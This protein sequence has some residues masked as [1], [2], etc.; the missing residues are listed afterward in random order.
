[1][2]EHQWG[3]SSVYIT[4]TWARPA[5]LR[6]HRPRAEQRGKALLAAKKTEKSLSMNR[7][8]NPSPQQMRNAKG[9][10]LAADKNIITEPDTDATRARS[11]RMQ[12]DF[13]FFLVCFTSS[14]VQRCL[15]PPK[16]RAPW[17][18]TPARHILKSS[19]VFYGPWLAFM[20]KLND[21]L[22]TATQSVLQM[23]QTLLFLQRFIRR[24]R[25]REK[26]KGECFIEVK[27]SRCKMQP[28][29]DVI[30]LTIWVRLRG[31]L[32][33][34][35]SRGCFVSSCR[36]P[37]FCNPLPHNYR[38]LKLQWSLWDLI[39]EG[40]NSSSPIVSL[41]LSHTHSAPGNWIRCCVSS[42][43]TLRVNRASVQRHR[44]LA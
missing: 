26:K 15:S 8:A 18:S 6:S 9:P 39:T 32:L 7:A 13:F 22:W 17:L 5:S 37:L 31:T 25:E 1:M 33:N 44:Q 27:Q 24:G 3:F 35:T 12:S 36:V 28:A 2:N 38:A 41:W 19:A 21:T 23:H 11:S 20:N 4:F 14:F 29:V 42:L 34:Q 43:L 30:Q 40:K 10:S 16:R